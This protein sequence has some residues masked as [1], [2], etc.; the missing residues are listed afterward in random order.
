VTRHELRLDLPKGWL[1]EDPWAEWYGS[2][3][4]TPTADGVRLMPSW[5]VPVEIACRLPPVIV[6]PTPHPLGKRL[7]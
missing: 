5:G 2:H 6:L 4:I 3:D 7:L 1:P